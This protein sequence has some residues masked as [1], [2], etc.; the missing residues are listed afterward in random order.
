M[1]PP[2]RKAIEVIPEHLH[3]Y[4][5]E[6]DASLYTAIDHATWRYILKI[7]QAFF[8]SKAHPKYQEGLKLTGISTERI[9]LIS[10]M[11]A[12]L[13]QFG[14]R[15]VGVNGFI[16]PA[17]FMEF[18]SLGILPIACEMR[19][20]EHLAYTPAPD[21]VHEAAGHAPILA[22]PEYAAYLRNYGEISR[23][24]IY[25]NKDMAV[26]EAIRN[27]SDIKEDPAS[28]PVLIAKAQKDLETALAAVDYISEASYLARMFWWTVEYGLVGSLQEPLIYGAGLLSSVS[29]SYGCLDPSVG[30]IP[31]SMDC[32]NMSYDITRPQPQLFVTP[33]FQSLSLALDEFAQTMA[34][35]R[36][37]LEGLSKARVAGSVTT[38]VLNSGLQISGV[39]ADIS[40]DREGRP[41]YLQ[42]QGPCQLAV[43]DQELPGHSAK[44]H[45]QGFGT[46]LG[47]V[48]V[49]STFKLAHQLTRADLSN[50]GVITKLEYS[51]GVSVE[52]KL[53]D[54][55][56][57]Q[58]SNL[59]VLTFSECT[60]R[61]GSRILFKP[62]WGNYD[63]ALGS[64]VS[65]VYGGAADRALYLRALGGTKVYPS[66]PKTNL[67]EQNRGLNE[68]YLRVRNLREN[69][70][71]LSEQTATLAAID[72]ELSSRYPEDWLLSFEIL[73][74]ALLHSITGPFELSAK[75]R[76]RKVALTRPQEGRLI[77]RGMKL[78]TLGSKVGSKVGAH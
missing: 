8:L 47:E 57:D 22:D 49:G 52:G 39:L 7:S 14:W 72:Q 53:A 31:F 62:E 5:A 18:Q 41:A 11:D 3:P 70:P 67:T 30:K 40:L 25:S 60:V 55:K 38:T 27:L 75:E 4:V 23:K 24:A 58:N 50:F 51:S 44:Y 19:T 1:T 36:G 28:T 61:M 73:E 2:F 65:S 17:V 46:A 20:P 42:Y 26:Y 34:F 74:L 29:E 9:P 63:L 32:V 45:N 15:A 6:Q 66:K 71:S 35:K 78:L 12:C 54:V 21:I 59:L 48:K 68:L 76:L 10:E 77:E 69:K 56:Q 13:K 37:G 43:N 33:D 64:A 16:P